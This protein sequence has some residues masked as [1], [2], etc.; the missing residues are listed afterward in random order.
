MLESKVR[1]T[2][3]NDSDAFGIREGDIALETGGRARLRGVC[4]TLCN[5]EIIRAVLE[6]LQPQCKNRR[7]HVFLLRTRTN[8]RE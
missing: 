6:L 3:R 1:E 8:L 4:R 7:L 5:A 2:M